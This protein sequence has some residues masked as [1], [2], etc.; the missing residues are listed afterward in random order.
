ML[1]GMERQRLA[2]ARW[3]E[4][5]DQQRDSSGTVE[6]FCHRHGLAVS[7][8]FAWRRRLEMEDRPT[9]VE[10]TAAGEAPC[11]RVSQAIEVVLP[12][13]VVLRVSELFDEATLRRVVEVLS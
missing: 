3:R 11:D 2:A 7:T 10:L 13:G 8:F 6:A 9:F 1:C 12:S 4:L 5:I